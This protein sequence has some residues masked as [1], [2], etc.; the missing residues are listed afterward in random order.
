MHMVIHIDTLV[1]NGVDRLDRAEFEAA[2]RREL[3]TQIEGH[4]WPAVWEKSGVVP[5]LTAACPPGA[6]DAGRAGSQVARLLTG[7]GRS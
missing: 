4:G 1:L 2:L 3:L 5:S 7:G 6:I